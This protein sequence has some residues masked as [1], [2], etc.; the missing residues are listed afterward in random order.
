MELG[1]QAGHLVGCDRRERDLL[2][3]KARQH[4]RGLVPTGPRHAGDALD[5]RGSPACSR[6]AARRCRPSRRSYGTSSS[7]RRPQLLASR[8]IADGGGGRNRGRRHLVALS[9]VGAPA[10]STPTR[11]P[12]PI[13]RPPEQ[14][15]EATDALEPPEGGARRHYSARNRQTRGSRCRESRPSSSATGRSARCR[16]W[17]STRCSPPSTRPPR[18]ATTAVDCTTGSTW[19]YRPSRPRRP[20]EAPASAEGPALAEALSVGGDG[21]RDHARRQEVRSPPGGALAPLPRL[22]SCGVAS[23]A[24][25][26]RRTL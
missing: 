1:D 3:P 21:D 26:S 10:T 19:A 24:A 2:L 11:M 18:F 5:S 20:R 17:P 13:S 22:L 6:A 9:R 7:L 14:R 12:R 25:P 4:A 23:C 15:R 16:H 8:G